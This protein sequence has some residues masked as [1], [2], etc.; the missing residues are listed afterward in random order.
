VALKVAVEET[1]KRRIPRPGREL[2]PS[3][4][5][6]TKASCF[7]F[8]I[9]EEPRQGENDPAVEIEAESSWLMDH[10]SPDVPLHFAAFHPDWKMTDKPSTPQQTL[11]MARRIAMKRGPTLRLHWQH[12]DHPLS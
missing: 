12:A 9:D 5:D 10:V 2:P 11:R 8:K 1:P 6:C 4:W 7:A 3:R